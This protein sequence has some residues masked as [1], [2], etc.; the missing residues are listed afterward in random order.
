MNVCACWFCKVVRVRS[1]E[2]YLCINCEGTISFESGFKEGQSSIGFNIGWA[3]L[4]YDNPPKGYDDDA[5]T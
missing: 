4:N 3:G 2:R 1:E 5:G